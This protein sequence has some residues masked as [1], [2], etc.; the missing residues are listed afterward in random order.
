MDEGLFLVWCMGMGWEGELGEYIFK[1]TQIMHIYV[2]IYVYHERASSMA[3]SESRC[4]RRRA[5]TRSQVMRKLPVVGVFFRVEF[6]CL[7]GCG[8]C[9]GRF[10]GVQFVWFV[11]FGVCVRHVVHTDAHTN[12]TEREA[13]PKHSRRH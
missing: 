10:L 5:S 9:G 7:V 6:V 1:H 2:C 4:C 8:A 11:G 3:R 13:K 12:L